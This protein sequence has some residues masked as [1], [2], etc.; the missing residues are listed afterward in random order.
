MINEDFRATCKSCHWSLISGQQIEPDQTVLVEDV[1]MAS[2]DHSMLAGHTV[3]IRGF[4]QYGEV[5]LP[6]V[7][8]SR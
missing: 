2:R 1:F 5:G 6:F 3:E 8:L 7:E 4:Y